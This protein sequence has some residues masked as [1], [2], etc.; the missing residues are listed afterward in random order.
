MPI[1]DILFYIS[2]GFA[3]RTIAK[4]VNVS[5]REVEKIRIR[6]EIYHVKW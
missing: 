2:Q 1:L 5:L 4:K 3:N 6:A